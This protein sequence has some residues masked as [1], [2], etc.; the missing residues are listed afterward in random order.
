MGW[1]VRFSGPEG[2]MADIVEAVSTNWWELGSTGVAEMPVSDGTTEL[3]G[4]FNTDSEA[5]EAADALRRFVSTDPATDRPRDAAGPNGEPW[6]VAVEADAADWVDDRLRVLPWRQ[7]VLHIRPG[8]AFGHGTHPTT[9]LCLELL[10]DLDLSGQIVV[11]VG[12]GTGVLAIACALGGAAQAWG[13]D[14]DPEAIRSAEANAAA[15]GVSLQLHDSMA[16]APTAPDLLVV[17]MLNV[18]L[19][20]VLAEPSAPERFGTADLIVHSG[21]LLTAEPD[22]APFP[23]HRI[24]TTRSRV[25]GNS[26]G[27]VVWGAHLWTRS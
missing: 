1:V 18:D 23:H 21:F 9:A 6:S 15:N 3:V 19:A 24:T 16:A 4:G 2:S 25:A 17:N 27:D 10:A 22:P 14:N 5:N 26:S 20:H 8:Q 13:I 12:T 11:D 7:H